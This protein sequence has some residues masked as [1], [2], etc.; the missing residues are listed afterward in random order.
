VKPN[1]ALIIEC[2][3]VFELCYILWA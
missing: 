3:R 2:A 1:V